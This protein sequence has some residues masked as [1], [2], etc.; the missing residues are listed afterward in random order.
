MC[1]SQSELVRK[2]VSQNNQKREQ[3]WQTSEFPENRVGMDRNGMW[4]GG[5]GVVA[6]E[7]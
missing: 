6:R 5:D 7:Q 3:K 4:N 1:S 2:T